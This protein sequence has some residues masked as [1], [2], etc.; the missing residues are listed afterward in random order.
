[1][2]HKWKPILSIGY[3]I[4]LIAVCVLVCVSTSVYGWRHRSEG[5]SA[6][7]TFALEAIF[8]AFVA[9][10]LAAQGITRWQ[11]R[12]AATLLGFTQFNWKSS[13]VAETLPVVMEGHRHASIGDNYRGNVGGIDFHIFN[14]K[15]LAWQGILIATDHRL[16][17]KF[18]S[19]RFL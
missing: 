18:Y 13:A 11:Y 5:S 17:S 4:T 9:V 7:I 16:R 1:M 3:G 12:R 6:V 15:T 19:L 10:M 8:F 14:S 2:T